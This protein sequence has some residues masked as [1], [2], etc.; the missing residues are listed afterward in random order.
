MLID[1]LINFRKIRTKTLKF[2]IDL[3]DQVIV[4]WSVTQKMLVYKGQC[5][6]KS[7]IKNWSASCQ[8]WTLLEM[9]FKNSISFATFSGVSFGFLSIQNQ[10]VQAFACHYLK[11]LPCLIRI[12]A[13]SADSFFSDKS[14]ILICCFAQDSNQ[15]MLIS[16]NALFLPRPMNDPKIERKQWAPLWSVASSLQFHPKE[17]YMKKKGLVT[18]QNLQSIKLLLTL[19]GSDWDS[20]AIVLALFPQASRSLPAATAAN[21]ETSSDQQFVKV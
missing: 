14:L 21:L 16:S 9:P 6:K 7:A 18:A 4:C 2:R 13:E 17:F 3:Q 5:L 11:L 19:E 15:N 20:I 8:C 1:Q 10:N 12:W